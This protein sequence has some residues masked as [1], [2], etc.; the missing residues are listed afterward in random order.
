MAPGVKDIDEGKMYATTSYLPV[1]VGN[2]TAETVKEILAGKSVP[3][4]QTMPVEI[5]TKQN[6]EKY[7]TSCTY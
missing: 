3:K 7:R 6:I 2:K 1:P 4:R 5:I